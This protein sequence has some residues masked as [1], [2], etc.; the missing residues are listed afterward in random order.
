MID[1]MFD[2]DLTGSDVAAM[3]NLGPSR[4]SQIRQGALQKMRVLLESKCVPRAA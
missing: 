3:L 1:L 4:I 2:H